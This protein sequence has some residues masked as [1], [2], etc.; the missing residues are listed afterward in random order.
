MLVLRTPK[1]LV[2][3]K[4]YTLLWSR[5]IRKRLQECLTF[6][7]NLW[8]FRD[9]HFHCVVNVLYLLRRRGSFAR[10]VL[11]DPVFV[12]LGTTQ[13]GTSIEVINIFFILFSRLV[14]CVHQHT[15]ISVHSFYL[16]NLSPFFFRKVLF[17][18]FFHLIFQIFL[19]NAL[20]IHIHFAIFRFVRVL[21]SRSLTTITCESSL[22][23]S[24]WRFAWEEG[25]RVV[26]GR[27]LAIFWKLKLLDGL[28]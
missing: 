19:W 4:D 21:R 14:S 12:D 26:H 6:L 23:E 17:L 11:V 5:A 25:P 7:M 28:L 20:P 13:I 22:L 9:V 27:H 16:V 8:S 24:S 1:T 3:L 18:I 10:E 2:S 15:S